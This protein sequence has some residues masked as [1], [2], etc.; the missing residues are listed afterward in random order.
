[1]RIGMFF[2]ANSFVRKAI[3][4]NHSARSPRT[5]RVIL[6]RIRP[7]A[8]T[9]LLFNNATAWRQFAL[10]CDVLLSENVPPGNLMFIE[11]LARAADFC[12]CRTCSSQGPAL[13]MRTHKM[14]DFGLL[15]LFRNMSNVSA[16][17]YGGHRAICI[18]LFLLLGKL[19]NHTVIQSQN[20]ELF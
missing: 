13:L 9:T 17:L 5:W 1:M 18:G 10:R 6:S 12:S 2:L 7:P 11:E 8:A 14:V 16:I 3:S 19:R 15:I 4:E 20:F